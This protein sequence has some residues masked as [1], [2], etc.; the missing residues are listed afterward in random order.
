MQKWMNMDEH[1]KNT[2]KS[3]L[4]FRYMEKSAIKFQM[5][6]AFFGET[7]QQLP[8]TSQRLWW[9]NNSNLETG[10]NMVAGCNENSMPAFAQ[11]A[12]E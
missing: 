1:G 6:R 9:D 5:C 11:K 8:W 3:K 4:P 10:S 7:F 12:D 2:E